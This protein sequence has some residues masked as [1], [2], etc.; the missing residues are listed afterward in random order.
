[1]DVPRPARRLSRAKVV[2]WL[3]AASLLCAGGVMA[4]RRP[5]QL[6]ALARAEL[7]T[8]VVTRGPFVVQVHGAGTLRPE[9]VRWL[10]AE[11][12]GRIAAVLLEAGAEVE[13]ST[14][15]VRIENLDLRLQADHARRDVEESRARVLGLER[16]T[17]SD[18]LQLLAELAGVRTALNDARRSMNSYAGV[19]GAI[20]PRN[21]S[22]RISDRVLELEERAS[23]SELRLSLLRRVA[24]REVA[25]LRE[26]VA[27]LERVSEVRQQMLERLEVRAGSRG[28]LQDVLVELGQWVVPGTQVAKVMLSRQLYA[29]LRIPA[30]RIGQVRVGQRAEVRTSLGASNHDIPGRVRSVAPAAEQGTVEVEVSLEGELPENARPDQNVDGRIE[31]LHLEA[32]LQ[33]ARP[34]G[35]PERAEVQLFR[36]DSEMLAQRVNARIGHRSVD[37]VEVLAGLEAGQTVILSDMSRHSTAAAVRI[38]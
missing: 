5:A 7:W 19:E 15:I 12:S 33:V 38:E 34:V 20:V 16:Q 37:T 23:L 17:R 3:L 31:T 18:E 25:A 28:L 4:L 13:P 22:E 2:G 6:P 10:T 30:D 14:P 27:P 24:P 11:S 21:E 1:V 36:L 29:V 26:Q 32:A 35:L 8:G 9:A